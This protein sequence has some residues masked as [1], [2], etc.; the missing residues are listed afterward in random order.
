MLNIVLINIRSAESWPL[1]PNKSKAPI[2]E[3]QISNCGLVPIKIKNTGCTKK[4]MV[5]L[6]LLEFIF[7]S[8]AVILPFACIIAIAIKMGWCDNKPGNIITAVF[9]YTACCLSA[10]ISLCQ[11]SRRNTEASET[12]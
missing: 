7:L 10:C 2:S 4:K 12:V 6:K 1:G 5:I 11:R 9:S 8:F 3:D